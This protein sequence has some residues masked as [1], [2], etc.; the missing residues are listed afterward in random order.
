M[1]VRDAGSR[2]TLGV[3][4]KAGCNVSL[5]QEGLFED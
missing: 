4:V 5:T 3:V 2:V 1:G